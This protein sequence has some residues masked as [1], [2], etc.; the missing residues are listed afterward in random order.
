MAIAIPASDVTNTALNAYVTQ[1]ATAITNA[2]AG[3]AIL[4]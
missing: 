4:L 1:I 3:A 2:G